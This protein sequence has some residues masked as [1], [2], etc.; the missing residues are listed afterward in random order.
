[1]DSEQELQSGRSARAHAG[2]RALH[3][4]GSHMYCGNPDP[5]L[6]RSDGVGAYPH[7]CLTDLRNTALGDWVLRTYLTEI[8][9]SGNL[10]QQPQE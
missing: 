6:W 3:L 4:C 1:V 10:Q 9:A 5:L 8:A 7:T 2:G